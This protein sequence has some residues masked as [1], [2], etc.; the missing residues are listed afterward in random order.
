MGLQSGPRPAR[1]LPAAAEGFYE[2]LLARLP[3]YGLWLVSNCANLRTRIHTF[4]T[5][6]YKRVPRGYGPD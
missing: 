4:N 3:I 1:P 5:Y 2:V 6:L